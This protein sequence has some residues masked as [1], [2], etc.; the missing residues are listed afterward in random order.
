MSL[1]AGSPPA[2]GRALDRP[3]LF[4]FLNFH[5]G[6]EDPHLNFIYDWHQKARRKLQGSRGREGRQ[7]YNKQLAA[8]AL[9]QASKP[10]VSFVLMDRR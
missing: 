9:I 2:C 6:G 3:S 8:P 7:H 1:W 4:F 5:R 10:Q